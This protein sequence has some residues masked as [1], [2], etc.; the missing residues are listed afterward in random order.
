M[1]EENRRGMRECKDPVA[2]ERFR[3]ACDEYL[4]WMH[5]ARIRDAYA[6]QVIIVHNQK[7]LGSGPGS[8]EALQDAQKK[9]EEAGTPLPPQGEM[10]F[11]PIPPAMP[12]VFLAFALEDPT[13][14]TPSPPGEQ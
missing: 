5:N 3:R 10:M 1:S 14:M 2:N 9:A 6:G 8:L 7:I 11:V 13:A 12:D 4:W